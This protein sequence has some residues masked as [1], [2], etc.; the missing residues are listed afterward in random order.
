MLDQNTDRM[1]FVIGAVIV[2]AAIIFIANGTLPTLFAS[3]SDSFEDGVEKGVDVVKVMEPFG[4]EAVNPNILHDSTNI[5]LFRYHEGSAGTLT[6]NIAV[7][8]WG[9]SDATRVQVHGG[10]AS[11]KFYRNLRLNHEYDEGDELT[12]S[13]YLKNEGDSIL[14]FRSNRGQVVKI[15]PGD[16]GRYHLPVKVRNKG[17]AHLQINFYSDDVTDSLDFI[18]WRPKLENGLKMTQW[19]L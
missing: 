2:G 12:I 7:P 8:E 19:V 11:T 13:V 1:W 5:G 17:T 6:N 15:I 4:H 16:S 10:I 9:A 18:M 14:G 3:V